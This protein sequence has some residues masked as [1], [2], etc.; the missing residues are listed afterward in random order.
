[1]I[2]ANVATGV[3]YA[4]LV[5]VALLFVVPLYWM[6]SGSLKSLGDILTFPPQWFPTDLKFSNYPAAWKYAPFDRFFFNSFVTTFF[7]VLLEVGNSLLTAYALVF[8]RFPG[9][10]VIFLV[11]LAALFIP[12]EMVVIAN[13]ATVASLGWVDTFPGLILPGASVVVGMFLLR[14]HFMTVPTSLIEAAKLDGANH[15]QIL[16]RVV[17]PI[18]KPMVVTVALLSMVAKWNSYLWPLIV[19]NSTEMKTLPIGL[20]YL[21]NEQGGNQ[22][23]VIMAATTFIL[24]PIILVFIRWQRHIVSGLTS[25]ATKA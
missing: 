4:L 16:W 15:L 23:G 14:Q 18:S 3:K 7:G 6:V 22:W 21:F 12:V 11:M 1:M 9:K 5:L 25:G 10:N 8:L 13:Y 20:A 19:T 24:A 2:R 17:L